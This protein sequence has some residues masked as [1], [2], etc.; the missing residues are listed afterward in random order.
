MQKHE[1][2]TAILA[3]ISERG[4]IGWRG[5]EIRLKVPREEFQDGFTLMTYLKRMVADGMILETPEG[6]YI[7]NAARRLM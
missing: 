1:V 3:L 7:E 6:Q 2:E 4:P 5:L